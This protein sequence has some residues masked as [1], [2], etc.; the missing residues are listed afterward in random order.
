MPTE[1]LLSRMTWKEVKKRATESSVAILPVGATEE[2]GPHIAVNSDAD[3]AYEMAVRAARLVAEDVKPI[4]APTIPYG[5]G[6]RNVSIDFPGTLFISIET[7]KNLVKE[8][9]E[10]LILSGFRKVVIVDSHGGNYPALYQVVREI[11]EETNA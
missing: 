1:I 11:M 6:P 9:C 7:L 8:V 5:V 3:G 2:H 4:V 10:G